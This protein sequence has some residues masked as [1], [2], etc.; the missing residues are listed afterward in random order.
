MGAPRTDH[1]DRPGM[2]V[3]YFVHDI[4]HPDLA[5]RLALLREGG[6]E[7][8][9]FGFHRTRA[10][11]RDL[12]G[13]IIDL[14][15]TVD[16]RLIHRIWAVATALPRLRHFASDLASSRVL[17]ARNLEMLLL[18]AV[19]RR[20]YAPR[21]ALVYECLD[22]HHLMLSRGGVGAALRELERRLL[23]RSQGLV[24]SS[25]GFIREYFKRVHSSLPQS[26]VVENKVFLGG[27]QPRRRATMAPAGPPWRIGWFGVIR[28]RR[29]LE[30]LTNLV[31]SMP[32]LVQVMVAGMPARAVFGDFERDLEGVPGL[33]FLGAF[34][35]EAALA[36]LF[37]S[38]HFAWTV[39][40]YEADANSAWLL[41][42]RLYRAALYGAVPLAIAD[43]ETGKWLAARQAGILLQ[44]PLKE[45][46]LDT[47]RGMT[48]E[49]FTNAQAALERIPRSALV[50]EPGECG[51]LVRALSEL[52]R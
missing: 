11:D 35:D 25:P 47:I 38:V 12:V 44:E 17:L 37:S 8:M 42:N 29:S 2:K 22:I 27:E 46:L 1:A 23:G 28:C 36:D 51:A 9:V 43:V 31:R 34:K 6:A 7:T 21:A 45:S 5:R 30:I 39:D 49:R 15:R 18:A 32:E 16:A 13:T 14:G 24:V 50:T 40:Y 4:G 48:L 41:P 52:D 33:T 20:L 26:F 19:A 10:V 3:S